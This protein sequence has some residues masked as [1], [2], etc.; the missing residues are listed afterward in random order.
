MGKI[1]NKIITGAAVAC[2]ILG[3]SGA[4]GRADETIAQAPAPPPAVPGTPPAPSAPAPAAPTSPLIGPSITGPLTI[5]LPPPKYTLPL[6][7]DVYFDGIGSG[8]GQWQNN[9]FLGNRA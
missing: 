8:L 2:A 5:Q 1:N 9:P 7:G 4:S 3:L 6:L